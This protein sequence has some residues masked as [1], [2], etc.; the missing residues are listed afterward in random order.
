MPCQSNVTIGDDWECPKSSLAPTEFVLGSHLHA[1]DRA[2]D[3]LVLAKVLCQMFWPTVNPTCSIH[4][5]CYWYILEVSNSW[6][7]NSHRCHRILIKVKGKGKGRTLDIAPQEAHCR[8][9][10]AQVHGAHKQRRTYLPYTFPTV[11]GT[12]L[13]TPRGWRVE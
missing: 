2:C 9:R 3:P 12:H 6:E 13:L 7:F 1:F 4:P 10:G 11:A 8:C 5:L